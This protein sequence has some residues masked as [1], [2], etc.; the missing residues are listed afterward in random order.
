MK[1]T[2]GEIITR[3]AKMFPLPSDPRRNLAATAQAERSQAAYI[4]GAQWALAQQSAGREF[5][6]CSTCQGGPVCYCT[7]TG[8]PTTP[9]PNEQWAGG[10][11]HESDDPSSGGV[12]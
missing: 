3:A 1:P 10:R 2:R 9:Q 8:F 7:D 6:Q 12:L 5:A 4:L 11:A